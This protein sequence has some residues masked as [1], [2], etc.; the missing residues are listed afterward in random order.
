[1]APFIQVPRKA[2]GW[3][4]ILLF[5]FAAV[6]AGQFALDRLDPKYERLGVLG[7][8]RVWLFLPLTL[9]VLRAEK[10]R[11]PHSKLSSGARLYF[12]SVVLLHLYLAFTALWT[13]LLIENSRPVSNSSEVLGVFLLAA[14]MFLALSLFRSETVDKVRFL[15]VLLITTA[16]VYAVGGM[17]GQWISDDEARMSAFGGGPNVFV[18]IVGMGVFGAL[19]FW[20]QTRR[21]IWLAPVPLLVSGAVLS[22][23][24]GGLLALGLSLALFFIIGFGKMA[25]MSRGVVALSVTLMILVSV[26]FLSSKILPVWQERFIQLSFEEHYDADRLLLFSAAVQMFLDNPVWG[27]GL[28]GFRRLNDMGGDYSHNLFLQVSAEGGIVG[29]VLLL[30]ALTAGIRAWSRSSPL[31]EQVIFSLGVF[32]FLAA[33]L[34][35]SYYDARYM[36]IFFGILWLLKQSSDRTRFPIPESVAGRPLRRPDSPNTAATTSV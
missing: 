35:G 16:S 4:A 19:Y 33:L 11:E 21:V 27:V 6:L 32:I 36:W 31:E 9:L 15:F 25:A 23:S 22:G 30:L 3:H 13:P 28:D 2:R 24:R 26:P 8:A 7:Q 10:G 14:T 17:S 29:L 1:M 18:R 34:S 5:F 12:S 20:L